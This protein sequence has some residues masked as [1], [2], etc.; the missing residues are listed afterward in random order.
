MVGY[1][2][3][4][5]DGT[6]SVKSMRY[7]KIVVLLFILMPVLTTVLSPRPILAQGKTDL[8][9]SLVTNDYYNKVTPGKDN[10]FFLKAW[11]AGDTTITN[12]RLSSRA[13]EGWNVD[14][15]QGEIASLGPNSSQTIEFN[16]KPPDRV[17]EDW[18]DITIIADSN[19]TSAV[20]PIRVTVEAPKDYWLWIGVILAIVVVA[21][22]IFVF[23]RFGRR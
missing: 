1:L 22:F 2:E 12:I 17:T 6:V 4:I 10:P 20:L 15:I 23:I 18:Y 5:T 14:F 19:E 21:G 3:S 8:N 13:P 11:N 16:V 7:I 9:L